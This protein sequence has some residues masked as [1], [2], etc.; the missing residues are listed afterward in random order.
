M[1]EKNKFKTNYIQRRAH[2]LKCPKKN[3]FKTNNIQRRAYF[4]LPE[5]IN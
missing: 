1:P 3:K 5:K 2:I 4:E